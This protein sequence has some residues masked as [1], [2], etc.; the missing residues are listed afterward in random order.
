VFSLWRLDIDGGAAAVWN[1]AGTDAV[2]LGVSFA[3]VDTIAC[4]DL[5]P[6]S[7]LWHSVGALAWDPGDDSVIIHCAL[8][9][10][11]AGSYR[12]YVLKWRQ[13]QG[14]LWA[15]AVAGHL[16][17]AGIGNSLVLYG[18]YGVIDSAGL[19]STSINTS[20]G[21]ATEQT[22][23]LPWAL[24]GGTHWY[25]GATHA[26]VVYGSYGAVRLALERKQGG[27][28]AV[29]G[30][31][32]DLCARAGLAAADIDVASL[33]G[34]VRGYVV[35]RPMTVR[36][37]IEPLAAAY[38]FDGVE[39]D[40]VLCFRARGRPPVAAILQPELLPLDEETGEAWRERRI[41]EV[42]L[43]ERVSV[44]YMDCAADYS[45]GSQ[46]AKRAALP[47]PAMHSRNQTSLELPIAI[48]ATEAKAIAEQ[49]LY[50]AWIERSRYEAALPWQWLVLDPG[51]V[52]DVVS[53]DGTAFRS[54]LTRVDAGADFAVRLHA[55]SEDAAA[56]G[57]SAVPADG[58]AGVAAQVIPGSAATR[59]I[60]A[61]LPLLR[62]VDDT[63]G[64]GSR[65]YWLMAGYGPPGWPGAAL[66]T[67]PDGSLWSPAGQSLA[68]AACGTTVNALGPPRSAF[69]TD[70][71]NPLTL[72]MATG[73]DRLESVTQLDL[74]NG[75]N[76]ALVLKANGE[77]EIIQ[78]RDVVTNPDGSFTLQGLLRGRRG[79]DVFVTGHQ[80]GELFV[81]LDAGDIETLGVGL[82]ELNV[83]R[84]WRAVGFGML[85]E[86]GADGAFVH[87]G[88]DLKPY[89]PVHVKAVT[90]GSPADI[91]LSWLRRSR[92]GGA[93]A[94]G[95]G[96]V[97]L[98]EAAEAY[99]VD[100]LASPGGAVRRTLSS[101]AP[102]VT[103][104]QADI[105]AD[106]G[107]VPS[108]LSVV[109]YQLSAVIGR[110][111]GRAV[112]LEVV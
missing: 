45:Q 44:V 92:I 40:D 47:L 22:W 31:V 108:S 10:G 111:F 86:E 41:Q 5:L 55:V 35:S 76:P 7:T 24:T 3:K 91:T 11:T 60:L 12:P 57:T 17:G 52:I 42:E 67:S 63:G 105:V 84:H 109:V 8:T 73:G 9:G 103:Y 26:V 33:T 6:G 28:A 20:T 37:A 50:A 104:T 94:D 98:G 88:R 23:A 62:D 93:L 30:I 14:V 70:E 13:G 56:Y 43:P 77:A 106:F 96:T 102:S 2:T 100:I 48:A 25:D 32:S 19:H 78:F 21:E 46:S 27:D 34:S 61:D 54:R 89:A 87:T 66:Y 39:S 53:D 15:T 85:F 16:D 59:L 4:E 72:V 65:L 29:A 49:S 18:R 107:G 68:E 112:T 69:A 74:V 58:G 1:D 97:P 82:G 90:G 83:V 110:G 95:T 79:S 38:F 75:A 64:S 81:L 51:D 36:A 99:E 71:D 80:P 101:S